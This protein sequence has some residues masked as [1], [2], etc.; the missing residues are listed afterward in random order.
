MNLIKRGWLGE[1]K[2]LDLFFGTLFYSVVLI[3]I[4][5]AG[6]STFHSQGHFLLFFAALYILLLP[7]NVWLTVAFWQSARHCHWFW[8]YGIWIILIYSWIKPVLN[9]LAH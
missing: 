2:V 5:M 3:G 4:I 9:W 8:K 7:L 1:L 6:V